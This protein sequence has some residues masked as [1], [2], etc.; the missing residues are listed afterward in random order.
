MRDFLLRHWGELIEGPT[1]ASVD[2][3]YLSSCLEEHGN[4]LVL[5]FCAERRGPDRVVKMARSP[6][7]EFKIENEIGALTELSGHDE[8]T[9]FL[10][11]PVGSGRLGGRRFIVQRA[12]PGRSLHA[13]LRAGGLTAHGEELIRE[14]VDL[15]IR[16]HAVPA[17]RREPAPPFAEWLGEGLRG[18]DGRS[19]PALSAGKLAE[20]RAVNA[21]LASG[22]EP[23]FQHGD[24]WP[25][26]LIVEP[27]GRR[28]GGVIDWELAT[29]GSRVPLDLVWFLINL[30][31]SLH[32]EEIVGSL[33][34]AFRRSFFAPGA[35]NDRLRTCYERYRSAVGLERGLGRAVLQLCLLLFSVRELALYGRHG[36]MDRQC[37]ELLQLS[38]EKETELLIE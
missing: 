34:P 36:K 6:A 7:Y 21:R 38:I 8:L 33:V 30:A 2:A 35:V 20:L 22:L 27:G 24:Y 26:N 15:M 17:G 23:L 3:V 28:I 13:I 12:I 31:F 25:A 16:C 11:V 10:P 29:A 1:P 9:P 32:E 18:G 37:A 5:L 14:A 4:D 19:I